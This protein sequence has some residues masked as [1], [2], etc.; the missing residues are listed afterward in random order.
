[1]RQQQLESKQPL[2]RF[3]LFPGHHAPFSEELAPLVVKN[4][5]QIPQGTYLEGINFTVVDGREVFGLPMEVY[6]A[7]REV[8]WLREGIRKAGRPGMAIAYYPIS[9]RAGCLIAPIN[10]VSGIRPTDGVLLSMLPDEKIEQDLLA[11]AI[12]YHDTGCFSLNGGGAGRPGSF[13][14][15]IEGGI[16]EGIARPILGMMCYRDDFC[17]G[18]LE[19]TIR[20]T[21]RT[22]HANPKLSWGVS[23]VCQALNRFTSVIYYGGGGGAGGG[24]GPGTI[25]HLWGCAMPAIQ[26]PINGANLTGARQSRA[27]MNLS[28]TPLEVEFKLEVTAAAL[29]AGLD[30][31]TA[32]PILEKIAARLEG[33]PP[34]PPVAGS[35]DWVNHKPSPDYYEKYLRVKGELSKMGLEF[36]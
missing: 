14:G 28:Q 33:Q 18:G 29:R 15:G 24:S 35:Y 31:R 34:E 9:T 10:P 27:Q 8:A 2:D 26:G 19:S 16:I 13:I 12:V 11:A 5:A 22:I 32:T 20:T 1:M 6:A 23:V 3:N 25:T 36:G 17:Y 21:A 7:R 4:F 30:R